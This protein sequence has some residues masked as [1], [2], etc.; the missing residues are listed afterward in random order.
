[1][2]ATAGSGSGCVASGGFAAV[3]VACNPQRMPETAAGVARLVLGPRFAAAVLLFRR[4]HNSLPAVLVRDILL[5][6]RK[7]LGGTAVAFT[8][9][10]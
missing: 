10:G 9:R 4:S 7:A 8:S 1:M 3:L 2:L 6:V 5:F